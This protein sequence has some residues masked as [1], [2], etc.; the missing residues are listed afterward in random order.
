ML[1]SNTDQNYLLCALQ[2]YCKLN[3]RFTTHN[4]VTLIIAHEE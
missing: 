4:E 1:S 3:Y 2:C